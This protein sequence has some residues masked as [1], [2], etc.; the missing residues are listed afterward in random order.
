MLMLRLRIPELLAKRGLT[1]YALAKRS[2]GR[3]SM[4]TAYRLREN[5]GRLE[6]FSA[7]LIEGLLDVFAVDIAEL[8]ERVPERRAKAK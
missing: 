7:T 1:P 5:G 2:G 4:S 8:M 3:I 6:T